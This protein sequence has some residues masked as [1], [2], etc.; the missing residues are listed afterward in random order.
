LG[1]EVGGYQD[2]LTLL[3]VNP[4]DDHNLVPADPDELLD[5]TDTTPGQL[6][7]E[8]HALDVVVLEL[9]GDGSAHES[10]GSRARGRAYEFNIGTH[11]LN[12]L[13]LDHDQRVDLKVKR[14][15]GLGQPLRRSSDGLVRVGTDLGEPVGIVPH[16]EGTSLRRRWTCRREN[17]VG[18]VSSGSEGRDI[19]VPGE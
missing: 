8:N 5:G 19:P 16:D 4:H 9:R 15:S 17:E 18:R 10:K 13:D 2:G 3:L 7:K 1:A 11:F 14:R 12:L 6:G